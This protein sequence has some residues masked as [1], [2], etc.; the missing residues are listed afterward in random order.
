MNKIHPLWFLCL[1]VRFCIIIIV[2]NINKKYNYYLASVLLFIG[3]G[4]IYK[5]LVGSN[6]EYQISKVFWHETRY[7]HGILFISSAGYLMKSNKK[8][9]S[10]V[11]LLDILF[12]FIYRFN[13][14]V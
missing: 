14:S 7:I 2:K 4:F 12:S 3:I 10:I 11:L 5:G 8:I 13:L 1:L 6:K 9:A